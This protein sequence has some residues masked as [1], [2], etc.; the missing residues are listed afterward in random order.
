MRKMKK[1]FTKTMLFIFALPIFCCTYFS[2]F[3]VFAK[4]TEDDFFVEGDSDLDGLLDRWETIFSHTDP[5]NWDTDGDE[6]SDGYEDLI[7]KTDPLKMDTDGNGISDGDEDFDKDG[8]I[9]KKEQDL[10]VIDAPFDPDIDYDGLLDGE[11]VLT[12]LTDPLDRDTDKDRILDGDEIA[13]GLDPHKK[14]T[15]KGIWDIDYMIWQKPKLKK[16]TESIS[17]YS[18]FEFSLKVFAAGNTEKI[19]LENKYGLTLRRNEAIIGRVIDIT[20]PYKLT[21]GKMFFKMKNSFLNEQVPIYPERKL[22][23]KRYAIFQVDRKN[24]V[25]H[26]IPT[27]YKEKENIIYTNYVKK[28]TFCLVDLELLVFNLGLVKRQAPT[29]YPEN[30][31]TEKT[32]DF[33]R[34]NLKDIFK[35]NYI[36][37]NISFSP[38]ASQKPFDLIF[39]ID[40]TASMAPYG[41]HIKAN[42]TFLIR[43]LTEQNISFQISFIDFKDITADGKTSTKINYPKNIDFLNEPTDMLQVLS[44]IKMNGGKDFAE[45]PFDAL[46]AALKL[47][48]RKDAQPYV[49]ILTNSDYKEE[50]QYGWKDRKQI[51]EQLKKRG[52]PTSIVTQYGNKE[53]Y[54]DLYQPTKGRWFDLTNFFWSDIYRTVVRNQTKPPFYTILGINLC[55]IGLDEDLSQSKKGDTDQDGLLDTEEIL[56]K[57][58]KM[59]DNKVELPKLKQFVKQF[60]QEE[61]RNMAFSKELLEIRILTVLSDPTTEDLDEDYYKDPVDPNPFSA[62]AMSMDD[63]MLDYSP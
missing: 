37:N 36:E 6:L 50:N 53:L 42:L 60:P 51:I 52:I 58:I 27:L 38:P 59:E 45:T 32:E 16:E 49:F 7:T 46:G 19:L 40:S 10:P 8:L 54:E 48:S 1:L 62:D 22:G 33:T 35:W 26:P 13:I 39:A 17:R 25:L 29:T 14:K 20:Y 18:P 63:S 55:A 47:K 11:E 21:E 23:L 43:K 24:G 4:E 3:F 56:W 5:N 57:F 28:G 34:K 41:N 30:K 9:N 15:H 2:P 61:F 44:K 31:I 12:Y